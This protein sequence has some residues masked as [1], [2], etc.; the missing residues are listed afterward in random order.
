MEPPPQPDLV[1]AKATDDEPGP[2]ARASIDVEVRL[3]GN[4]WD[5]AEIV[6]E[7]LDARHGWRIL[8][9]WSGGYE[10]WFIPDPAKIR[11]V[12]EM[13]GSATRTLLPRYALEP[14]GDAIAVCQRALSTALTLSGA[15][16]GNVQLVGPATGALRIVAQHGFGRRFLDFFSAVDGNES[17]CGQAF[18]AAQPVWV[19]DVSTS[20]VFAGSEARR[21]VLGAGVRAVAS[22]PVLDARGDVRAVLSVHGR[23]QAIWT[24]ERQRQ[25]AGLALATSRELV[26]LRGRAPGYS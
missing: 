20:P 9:R 14:A 24:A 3:A 25:L 13:P 1:R 19:S 6:A 17:A 4:R 21:V 23:D 11:R 10:A 16:M 15:D 22:V 26:E 2:M 18:Q 12:T 5:R 8:L 7:G